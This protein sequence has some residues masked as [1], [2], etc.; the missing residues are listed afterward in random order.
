MIIKI[1][2]YSEKS[3]V[4][5]IIIV[6]KVIIINVLI[7]IKFKKMLHGKVAWKEHLTDKSSKLLIQN[8]NKVDQ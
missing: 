5:L 7:R 2:K 1:D 3:Y 8:I 6:Q 4:S